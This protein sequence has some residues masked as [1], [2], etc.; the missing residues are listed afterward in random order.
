[1]P[2]TCSLSLAT[3]CSSPV[4]AAKDTTWDM[5]SDGDE[6]DDLLADSRQ[7]GDREPNPVWHWLRSLERRHATTE[8]SAKQKS[9]SAAA[10]NT[11]T[12]TTGK[13]DTTT[14]KCG[15]W[16]RQRSLDEEDSGFTLGSRMQ[17]RVLPFVLDGEEARRRD[18]VW[19]SEGRFEEAQA[20]S[21]RVQP[22]LLCQPG[23]ALCARAS[24]CPSTM[25]S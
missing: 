3:H 16:R 21:D 14:F 10:E 11:N 7:M 4:M 5:D 9:I 18:A 19:R 6:D 13:K 15:I 25:S 8:C 12:N 1:M 20:H 23:E 24:R 17:T 2:G 22:H